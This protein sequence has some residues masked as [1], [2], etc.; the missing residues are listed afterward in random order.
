MSTIALQL[1]AKPSVIRRPPAK[2]VVSPLG[3]SLLKPLSMAGLVAV[4]EPFGARSGL[5]Q[6][7]A[8]PGSTLVGPAHASEKA[9]TGELNP[10]VS[11]WGE[12][13]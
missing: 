8:A 1:L 13:P 3:T 9:N 7:L 6:M 12:F 10:W 5:A 11:G 4:S 2:S